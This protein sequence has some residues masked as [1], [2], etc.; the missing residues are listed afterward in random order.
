MWAAVGNPSSGLWR[1]GGL[2]NEFCRG[3]WTTPVLLPTVLA[4]MRKRL[5][6]SYRLRVVVD[7]E[8]EPVSEAEAELGLEA[9]RE[10]LQ[11]VAHHTGWAL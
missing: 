4:S 5:D 1:H 10:L 6:A 3:R 9:I 2:I 8:A 11:L 7:Y